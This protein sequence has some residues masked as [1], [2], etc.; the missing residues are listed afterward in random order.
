MSFLRR[1]WLFLIILLA[2]L[3]RLA[4]LKEGY[5]Y[6]HDT[7]RDILVARGAITLGQIPWV[8]SF[9]SAGPFVF[10]PQWYWFLVVVNLFFPTAEIA[11]P[12]AV[13]AV[14]LGTL[15]FSVLTAK[16]LG[17]K[18]F[19]VITGLFLALSPYFITSAWTVSQHGMTIFFSALTVFAAVNLLKGKSLWW[20]LVLGFAV[21]MATSLHTQALT[22]VLFFLPPVLFGKREIKEILKKIILITAGFLI[23]LGPYLYWDT[24]NQFKNTKAILDFL[25]IGQYRF[26]VPNRW[27]TYV[28][29]FWSS[30]FGDYFGANLILG[31]GILAAVFLVFFY[32]ILK[33][34]LPLGLGVI[35]VF[36]VLEFI[37]FR[38]YH[39]ERFRGYFLFL[40]PVISLLLA[41]LLFQ[42][43]KFK[44]IFLI[45]IMVFILFNSVVATVKVLAQNNSASDMF[46]M[47]DNLKS[48]YPGK[49]FTLYTNH[50]RAGACSFNFDLILD[51]AGLLS[52]NGYPLG[53]CVDSPQACSPNPV[54]ISTHYLGGEKCYLL[55]LT[56]DQNFQ[57]RLGWWH[58]FDKRALFDEV[59]NWWKGK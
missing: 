48:K 38:Y 2:L 43:Y 52:P 20:N 34:K 32:G 45:V 4:G 14:S 15:L 41:W 56:G 58:D 33:R 50:P 22:L 57:S 28:F 40:D 25:L 54:L 16:E 29:D 5:W 10:G 53:M 7:A 55:D 23:G 13:I 6:N 36:F 37:L 39:G 24:I 19:A 59:E 31:F 11:V 26:Y 51:S 44:K 49:Q 17:G 9:S 18:V 12:I 42:V 47:R 35:F 30:I 46:T 8:G 21:G 3:L 1:H 27:L